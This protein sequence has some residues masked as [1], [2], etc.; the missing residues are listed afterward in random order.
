MCYIPERALRKRVEKEAARK[1]AKEAARKL[2][3]R[4]LSYRCPV[5]KAITKGLEEDRPLDLLHALDIAR[6]EAGA[7]E[8]GAATVELI[9]KLKECAANE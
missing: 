1:L 6:A 5:Y 8:E 4:R 3:K 9:D 2:A 7:L